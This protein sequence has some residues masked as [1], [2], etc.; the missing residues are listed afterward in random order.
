MQVDLEVLEN[1][2]ALMP[3]HVYWKDKEGVLQGCNNALAKSLGLKSRKDIVG[4]TDWDLAT[5]YRVL[6]ASVYRGGD[7]TLCV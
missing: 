3:D 6:D 2:I 4:K 5:V 7:V 1:I